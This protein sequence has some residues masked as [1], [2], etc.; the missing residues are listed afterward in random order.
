MYEDIALSSNCLISTTALRPGRVSAQLVALDVNA[1][2]GVLGKEVPLPQTPEGFAGLSG[3][4]ADVTIEGA[5]DGTTSTTGVARQTLGDPLDIVLAAR[6]GLREEGV[7]L[8]EGDLVSIG[9]L[10]TPRPAHAG[11]TLRIRYRVLSVS[12]E[13]SVRFVP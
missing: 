9:T 7:Q 13:I 12:S 1:R 8:K 10:T 6:D 4:A 2:S 3:L 11:E 5:T